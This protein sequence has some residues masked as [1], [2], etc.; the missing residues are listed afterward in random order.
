M[1]TIRSIFSKSTTQSTLA[2]LVI[3]TTAAL[4]FRG[5]IDGPSFLG[6][7]IVVVGYYFKN[8]AEKPG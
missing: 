7:A 5:D 4:A 6:V 8:T 2:F 3:G 1:S